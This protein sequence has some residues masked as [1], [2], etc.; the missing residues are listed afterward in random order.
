MT[1]GFELGRTYNRR[2]DIHARFSG[3]QQGGIITPKDHNLIVIVT[4]KEG[5]EHG[6]QD[7]PRSDGVFEYFGEGQIGD[8]LMTKG[9]KAIR[10]HAA[11]SKDLL[12]FQ[13]VREGLRYEGQFVV[14]SVVERQAPDTNDDMRNAFVFELRPLEAVQESIANTPFE[15]SAVDLATLREQALAAA[16]N[17][18]RKGQSKPGSIFERSKAVRDYVLARAKAKCEDCG[19]PAPFTTK[20]GVPFLEVHHIRRLSDG[21]PDDPRFMIGLCPNCHRRAHY[22]SDAIVRNEE[23]LNFVK[24]IEGI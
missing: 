15:V 22:G 12:L 2:Q 19:Q 23:M 20:R 10:D 1:W 17:Q 14:E 16:A 7:G 21:G 13:K 4:G 5:G 8:M 11:N 3:Q 18:P 24:L 9:N 6:Y